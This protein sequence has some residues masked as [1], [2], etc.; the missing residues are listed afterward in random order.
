MLVQSNVDLESNPKC[1]LTIK[2]VNQ[3]FNIAKQQS[4]IGATVYTN[5]QSII[6]CLTLPGTLGT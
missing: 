6:R 5:N 2:T 4:H 3:I 1:V